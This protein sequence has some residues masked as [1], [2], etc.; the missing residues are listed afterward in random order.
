MAVAYLP[1][2]RP[3]GTISQRTAAPAGC[4]EPGQFA[5]LTARE[6]E[7]APR[8]DPLG[9]IAVRLQVGLPACRALLT[10]ASLADAHLPTVARHS[11]A[12][13]VTRPSGRHLPTPGWFSRPSASTSTLGRSAR[14]CSAAAAGGAWPAS[15]PAAS[16]AG[17]AAA[18]AGHHWSSHA[19]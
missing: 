3:S 19:A 16:S 15:P 18:T 14:V 1:R 5:A 6:D 8:A 10:P 17:S 11:A 12:P 2:R 7:V 9:A 4:G 13:M